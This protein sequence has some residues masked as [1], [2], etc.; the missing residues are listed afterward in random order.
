MN[1]HHDTKFLVTLGD[2]GIILAYLA[3]WAEAMEFCEA[4][5]AAGYCEDQG[6]L[7]VWWPV[8]IL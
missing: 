7:T 4:Y 1:R 3:N 5:H 6:E 8:T 2:D